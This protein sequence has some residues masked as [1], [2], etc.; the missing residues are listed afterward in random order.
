MGAAGGVGQRLTALL[1][2]QGH[3]VT[4]MHRAGG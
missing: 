4:G 2:E 1:T 3:R